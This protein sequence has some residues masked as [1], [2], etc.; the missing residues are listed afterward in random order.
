MRIKINKILLTVGL[1]SLIAFA[2]AIYITYT[3]QNIRIKGK[4]VYAPIVEISGR[5]S[6]PNSGC[7]V[8][9][10]SKTIYA[11][12]YDGYTPIGDTIA[13]R[14]IPGEIRVIQERFKP[15]R[16]YLLYSLASPLLILGI[17]LI[18]ESF[19]GKSISQYYL[20]EERQRL[21]RQEKIK[22]LK[23]KFRIK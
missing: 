4:L 22:R 23:S 3:F 21:K 5:I 12:S 14:Y 20:E 17:M 13:V 9:I 8:L 7:S 10:N 1:A 2:F 6:R 11:G 15:N 18:I 19:K 16:Y